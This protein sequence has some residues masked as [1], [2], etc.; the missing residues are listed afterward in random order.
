[1]SKGVQSKM[2]DIYERACLANPETRDA[3]IAALTKV[4]EAEEAKKQNKKEAGGSL[5]GSGSRLG[6]PVKEY[7]DVYDETRAI[8]NELAGA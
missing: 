6:K 3:T 1:M 2:A 7:E 5:S 4:K 8:Y